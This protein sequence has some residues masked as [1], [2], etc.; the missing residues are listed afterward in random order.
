MQTDG[1]GLA[2]EGADI[3]ILGPA[4]WGVIQSVTAYTARGFARA[5]RVLYVEPFGSWITLRRTARWQE[6]RLEARPSIE[7]VADNLWTYRPP[8]VGVPG[9]TRWRLA[10]EANGVILAWLLRG[11]ARRLG[12]RDPILWSPL[13][14]SAALFR[15]FPARLRIFESVDFDAAMARDAAHRALVLALE[16]ESCRAADIVLAV[17]EELA[18]PLRAFN[19]A[20]HVVPCAA[21]P[22]IFGRALLA[23]TAVPE[24]IAR[25][26]G[27]VIGYLGGIDPW[28]IDI[29]LLR[30]V[31]QSRPDWS[32]A[33]VG[34]VWFGFDRS[35]FADCPNI[36]LL[37]PQRYEDFPGFL[38]GMDACVMPFPLNEV[39]LRGDALKCYEYLAGGRPV[40]STP[41][42]AAR[43]LA[44]VVRIAE[45]PAAFIAA[46]E[47]A[48]ADPPEALIRRLAA[49]APH[50]WDA[51][52]R[53]KAEIIRA[54]LDARVPA[55]QG[56]A[57]SDAI[58]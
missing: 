30:Q 1:Q 43:R 47:A 25:L 54:A 7:E 45:T 33:L 26:P 16:E 21:A 31:A 56:R 28:K 49:V 14:N 37:G 55:R 18:A 57:R 19:P 27:P 20:T 34:Y 3:V 39:T 41:V 52:I 13:Y 58:A 36:H 29:G 51:R 40:V 53:Q 8:A 9:L 44:E 17:T 50:S 5:N 38:K 23:E 11:A 15:H 48:L 32:I 42:P 12:F 46:I 4:E 22:E 2:L 35:V 6:R 24:A 10:S